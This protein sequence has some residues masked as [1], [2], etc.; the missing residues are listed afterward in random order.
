V[1]SLGVIVEGIVV[2]WSGER[3]KFHTFI[4]PIVS[5]NMVERRFY[6]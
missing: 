3:G 5:K 4:L 1:A 2:S 6:P